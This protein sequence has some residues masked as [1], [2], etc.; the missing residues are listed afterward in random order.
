[1]TG[2]F[3]YFIGC[4]LRNK[5]V[6]QVRRLRSPRYA[7]AALLGTLYFFFIFGGW[8]I[9]E[10]MGGSWVR[11]GR[12]VAPLMIALF[13]SWWWLWGGHRHGLVLTPAEI[14]L[15]LPAPLK[16]AQLI[17]FKIM[18]AQ[19]AILF[20]AVIATLVVR[21]TGL[22]WMLRL[23]S[24]WLLLATLHLH[25]IAATLVHAAADEHGRHGLRRNLVPLM[26]FGTAL[27]I[28][29]A[30][31]VSVV[32]D[33][34]ASGSVNDAFAR[35]AAMLEE[36]GPRFVLAP[37]RLLLSP[38]LAPSA[39]AWLAPFAGGCALLL[40]HYWWVLRTD[41]AFEE[42]AAEEGRRRDTMRTAV[43]AGG[44]SRLKFAQRD[45]TKKI[46]RPW[47]PLSPGGRNAYAI[48]WKNILYTQR[49]AR[50][51]RLVVMAVSVVFLLAVTGDVA[52]DGM[53]FVAFV[54]LAIAAALSVFGP[55]GV[56]NDL[57][58]DLKNI[59][60]LRT[61]PIRSRDLVAAEIAA[62]TASL[63]AP[64]LLLL[65]AALGVLAVSGSPAP[66][67]A[68]LLMLAALAVLPVVNALSLLIQNA[69]ALLYP[70]WVRLGEQD[71]P[72]MEVI[73]QNMIV[74]FGTIVLLGIAAVPPLV[75]GGLVG[76]PLAMLMGETALLPGAAA[77]LLAAGGEVVLLIVW[78]GGLYER[79]DPVTA[80]LLR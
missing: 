37:F 72:G 25:Q 7:I 11:M 71:A 35:L 32:P 2:D 10:D 74:M 23:L 17:R 76:A 6:R 66:G 46:A 59:E 26:L 61:Y 8:A 79:T 48:F 14:H 39:S 78:L 38:A 70:S 73:G 75:A 16:R 28:L 33:I 58:M 4:T 22:H 43:R 54:L 53:R 77:A 15:L 45:R 21:G 67:T 19:P 52:V 68:A 20:S 44:F 3:A 63:T 13:A 9:D 56:R 12:S 40:A 30:S 51:T 49:S 27:L 64:Q 34:R 29:I 18:Q 47:L 36:P 55:L 62:A 41:A 5:V 80:G 1:M 24:V 31:L 69:L 57:R 65:V 60:L 50:P 42:T